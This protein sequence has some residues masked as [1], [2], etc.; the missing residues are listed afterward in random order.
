MIMVGIFFGYFIKQFNIFLIFK[1]KLIQ[2]K[3]AEFINGKRHLAKMMGLHP[4]DD[5]FE[6]ED[7]NVNKV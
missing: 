6:E 4:L 5:K 3:E 1:V 2:E 7:I